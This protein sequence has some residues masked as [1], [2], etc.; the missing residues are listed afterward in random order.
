MKFFSFAL[1]QH[2]DKIMTLHGDTIMQACAVA[3]ESTSTTARVSSAE[4]IHTHALCVLSCVAA[5]DEAKT[6]QKYLHDNDHFMKKLVEYTGS[7]NDEVY[8]TQFACLLSGFRFYLY[9]NLA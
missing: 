8:E 9:A 4:E 3:I 7:S 5:G 2:V 6:V 1:L